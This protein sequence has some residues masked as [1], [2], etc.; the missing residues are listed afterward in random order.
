M[1]VVFV[2]VAVVVVVVVVVVVFCSWLKGTV[3]PEGCSYVIVSFV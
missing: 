3:K 1:V 2:V